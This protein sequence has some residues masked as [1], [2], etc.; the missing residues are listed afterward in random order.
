MALKRQA[1][2]ESTSTRGA[3][4]DATEQ[5]MLEEGYAAVSSRKVALKAGLKSQLLHYHFGSMDD[6]FVAVFQRM[7]DRYDERFARAVASDHP[8]RE[9]W[10]LN[11][12][13]ASTSLILEFKALA[14]HRKAVRQMISRSA[15]RDRT[16]HAAALTRIMERGGGGSEGL[17]PIVLAVLISSLAR[18]LVTEQA[19]EVSE[20]HAET[21]AFIEQH[22]RRLE[23]PRGR[24]PELPLGSSDD[25]P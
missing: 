17:P 16:M 14:T 9:L 20:G 21:L 15:R 4:L 19:L 3:I 22:L 13:A 23:G 12:D 6:L 25:L 7:E 11:I 5:I 18:T 1:I 10:K 24:A 8:I 2:V